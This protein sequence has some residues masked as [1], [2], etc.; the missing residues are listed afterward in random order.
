MRPPKPILPKKIVK[1]PM[2]RKM[3]NIEVDE[4]GIAYKMKCPLC[5]TISARMNISAIGG[6]LLI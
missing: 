2:C 4:K 5:T 1:C 6:K 3:H